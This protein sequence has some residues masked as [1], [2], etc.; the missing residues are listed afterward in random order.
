MQGPPK[1]FCLMPHA[2]YPP[3]YKDG[4]LLFT[5]YSVLNSVIWGHGVVGILGKKAKIEPRRK[6]TSEGFAKK[7]S[8]GEIAKADAGKRKLM[9][10]FWQR[11]PPPPNSHGEALE[12]I[13]QGT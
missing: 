13:P 6:I 1:P 5:L 10:D 12:L 4:V 11:L 2:P 9:P 8:P 7:L 3:K